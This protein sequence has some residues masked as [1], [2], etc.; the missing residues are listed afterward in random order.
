MNRS[1]TSPR[2]SK[3]EDSF[4]LAVLA[5]GIVF[6]D[7]GT[8]PIYAFKAAFAPEYRLSATPQTIIGLLSL[9]I[10]ALV[11]T[12]SLKYV[13]F[14]MRADN[15]GEG[16]ILALL[17]LVRGTGTRGLV[18]LGLFGAA[19]LYGD[20]IITPAISVL[21]AVEGLGVYAPA[22][23]QLS[24]PLAVAILF[25]LFAV[26]RFGTMRVGW[27]FGPIMVVWFLTIGALGVVG[28]T[29]DPRVLLALNPIEGLRFLATHGFIGL[30][31]LGAVVLAVTGAE[32]LYADMGYFGKGPIRRAWFFL[33]F[34]ALVLNYAGQGALVLTDASAVANPFYLLVP[35]AFR[36]PMVA[37]ATAATVIAS[38]A[39]ISGVFALTNQTIQLGFSPRFDIVHTSRESKHVYVPA[40]NRLLM[41]ACLILVVTFRSSDALG[42]AYGIAVSGTMA[43]TTVLF[44]HV[45]RVN[46]HWSRWLA[47][48]VCGVF[49]IVDLA[50]FA[51][52]SLKVAHDGW[53]PLAVAIAIWTL[54]TTWAWGRDR[55]LAFRQS[56]IEPLDRFLARVNH[57][58]VG[59]VPGTTVY[60]TSHNDGVP[61]SLKRQVEALHVLTSE[62][63]LVSVDN[64][65]IPRVAPDE[66]V[67][68]EPRG[69]G[70]LSVT[71]R[72]GFL[73]QPDLAAA[74]AECGAAPR[75]LVTY[76]VTGERLV[77]GPDRN[78]IRRW[79]MRLFIALVRNSR[80]ATD[81]FNLP[82][83]QVIEIG[84]EVTL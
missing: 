5:V 53:V 3:P 42:A 44:Y 60:V 12:V 30:T 68:V 75:E 15:R 32:A 7:I 82:A 36:F 83:N 59:R 84:E 55:L 64:E 28:I 33:V 24:V 21:S 49:L 79:R 72:Y 50:F 63:V 76:V 41:I 34:P 61:R 46:W 11:V 47:G 1:V 52:N 62:I 77:A 38:Q 37:L 71:V 18:L 65:E 43:I 45:T 54:M 13:A 26:Q 14:I 23:A 2:L 35:S 27:V 78:V 81:F 67:R 74:L 22:L 39:L 58:G 66:R 51:A 25:V 29:R 9:V 57:D 70:F 20:G 19:L 17:A 4:R 56:E 10:W 8:S 80:T 69:G 40:V 6:G 73:E 48:L 31:V 16:G